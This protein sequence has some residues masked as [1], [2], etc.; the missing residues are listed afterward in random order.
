MY[1]DQEN[2]NKYSAPESDDYLP[3][4]TGLTTGNVNVTYN[5]TVI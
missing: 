5:Y 4:L 1:S 3:N 2:I